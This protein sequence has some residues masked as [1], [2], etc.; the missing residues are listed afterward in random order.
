M[1]S[2]LLTGGAGAI[3]CHV[4]A[5]VMDKTD[6]SV[7]VVDSFEH[8][9]NFARLEEVMKGHNW[10]R[11]RTVRHDLTTPLPDSFP[12]H[13]HIV[14]MA[15]LSDV[16]ES[17]TS[18][19]RVIRNNV[20]STLNMLD[21][22]ASH[23]HSTFVQFS[24]DEVYGDVADGHTRDVWD[25]HR[26]SNPYSA[27]KAACEDLAYA[28]WRAGSVRLVITNTTNNFGEM[29]GVSKYPTM[30]QSLLY[31]G[32]TVRVHTHDGKPGSRYY[33]HSRL[34]AEALHHILT[35]LPVMVHQRGEM[36]DPAKYHIA[37]TS[38]TDNLA[39]A[40][41]VADIMGVPLKYELVDC[42]V[43]NPAH[44]IH[45]GIGLDGVPGWASPFS[46]SSDLAHTVRWHMANSEWL[47]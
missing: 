41:M 3:G 38:A 37:G 25:P 36:D 10:G 34:V 7:T 14:H 31:R 6:W 44:D 46:F 9:G 5:H 23:E 30:L 29:Q 47:T 18:P 13:T 2:L 27:S 22:A 24:T 42:H 35:Q 45:Y 17:V 21:W 15:A 40:K 20:T 43:D 8:G 26:P 39:L 28:Y 11:L 33:I 12:T 19:H 4:V 1:T 32:E 16:A